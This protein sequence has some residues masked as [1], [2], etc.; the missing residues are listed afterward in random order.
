MMSIGAIV[1]LA[2][3]TIVFLGTSWPIFTELFSATK[4]SVDMA[5]YNKWSIPFA[6]L[7]MV[8]NALSLYMSWK[9]SN[10]KKVFNTSIFAISFALTMTVVTFMLG[11]SQGEYLVLALCSYFSVYVNCDRIFRVFLKKPTSTGAFMSHFGLSLL[12]LG[13]L[14]SG[15]YSESEHVT[16]T[17]GKS[18]EVLGYKVS[19]ADKIQI[20]KELQDREKYQ[21]IIKVEKDGNTTELK[22]VFYWSDFNGR[23][24]PFLE[25]GIA[26]RLLSDIYISP[27]TAQ[28][29]LNV[30]TALLEKFE[31]QRIPG[32]TANKV[33]L[34]GFDMSQGMNMQESRRVLLGVNVTYNIAGKEVKDTLYCQMS[35]ETL[36]GDPIMKQVPGTTYKA[37]FSELIRSTGMGGSQAAIVFIDET[38]P[39]PQ[40]AEIFTFDLAIK[41]FI[42][43][44]WIGTFFN[45]L[46][47]IIAIFKHNKKRK[48]EAA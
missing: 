11:V 19:F 12:I 1:I 2:L 28:T 42:N 38:K 39:I 36:M 29:S 26:P 31:T 18:K 16:L 37:G 15:A 20:E 13:S 47:F 48:I 45:I 30:P 14:F 3:T 17:K 8:L 40:A 35:M 23:Q 46:G 32:D 33:T 34:D 25:P 6:I 9:E 43:F 10:F 21:Y 24:A 27:K 44:V 4:S 5:F 7:I 41:P 22:P